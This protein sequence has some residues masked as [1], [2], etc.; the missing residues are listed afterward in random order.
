MGPNFHASEASG[1]DEDF[2]MFLCI[3]LVQIQNILRDANGMPQYTVKW[4]S[5]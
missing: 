3:S 4:T 1:S 2:S 5:I